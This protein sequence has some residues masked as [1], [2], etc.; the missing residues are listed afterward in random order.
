M[1]APTFKRRSIVLSDT[2]AHTLGLGSAYGKVV[3]YNVFA[4]AD[5]SVSCAVVDADGKTVATI[6]SA[7]YT[8][9][10]GKDG[11]SF[12]LSPEATVTEDGTAGTSNT[13]AV[14][15]LARSPLTLTASGL[16]SGTLTVEVYAQTNIKKRSTGQLTTTAVDVN[17]GAPFA[18]VVGYNVFSSADTTVSAAVVDDDGETIATVPSADY[19]NTTGKDGVEKVL[20]PE[21]ATTIGVTEDGT[22]STPNT[23]GGGVWAKSPLTVTPAGVGSG[24]ASIDFYVEV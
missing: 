4:S 11:K 18:Q 20:V 12:N 14:G 8:Q 6:P 10:T 1:S 7:D 23:I 19:T 2:S 24:Y 13:S 22:D 5:T 16:G 15:V 3:G 21:G 17:L 9:T